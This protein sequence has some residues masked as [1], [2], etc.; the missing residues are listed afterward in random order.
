VSDLVV[1]AIS[2]SVRE[3]MLDAGDGLISKSTAGGY[4]TRASVLTTVRSAA[5]LPTLD[6]KNA[7]PPFFS[8]GEVTDGETLVSYDVSA[9]RFWP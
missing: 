6:L 5:D 2:E 9:S 7:V 4:S 8:G 1:R 3:S